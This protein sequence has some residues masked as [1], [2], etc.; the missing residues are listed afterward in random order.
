M[1]VMRLS[2]CLLCVIISLLCCSCGF[3][4]NQR[5]TCEISDV[6][7][8]QLVKF[9]N[10]VIDEDTVLAQISDCP[11]FVSELNSLEQSVNWGEP[12]VIYENDVVIRI[13]YLNGDYDY[14]HSDTQV[15]YRNS[16]VGTGY[17]W[18]DTEQFDA[19][20]SSYLE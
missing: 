17:F 16:E 12:S 5:Y 13:H 6:E 9:G 8:I 2:L 20:I 15:F 14:I 19:L 1:K 4:G 7:S 3:L 10:G 18:F 11:K